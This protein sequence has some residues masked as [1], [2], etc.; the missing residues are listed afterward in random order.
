MA[1]QAASHVALP[2]GGAFP[3]VG[4]ADW[5]QLVLDMLLS[6]TCMC[7]YY[8]MA[9]STNLM[10]SKCRTRVNSDTLLCIGLV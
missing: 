3:T 1:G 7:W 8:Q 9:H 2:Q 6:S 10:Y 4:V 5:V